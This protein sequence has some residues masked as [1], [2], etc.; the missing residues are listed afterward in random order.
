[1]RPTVGVLLANLGSPAA[2]TTRA[3][4]R[5]LAQ[6]LADRRIVDLPR[7]PWWLLR[8]LIVLPLRS[9]RSAAL[10]RR[11]WT[12]QGSP[13]VATTLRLATAVQAELEERVGG[14]IPVA[15]GMRYGEPSLVAALGRLRDAGAGRIVV[16]PLF[17]QYS[18]ATTASVC[19]ALWSELGQWRRLPDLRVVLDYHAAPRYIAALAA[20]VREHWSAR[21]RDRRLLV[22]FH[23][24]PV[25]YCD[26]G[27]P[28]PAQCTATGRALAEALALGDREWTIAYQSRF[29][30]ERWLEPATDRML[31]AWGSE[32]LETADVVCPGFAADCLETLDEIAVLGGEQF[33][34]AGGGE[35]RYVPALNDRRDHA[36]ALAEIALERMD[37]WLG[38]PTRSSE[39]RG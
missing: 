5:Y 22:S 28:Y 26:A 23:G 19:D 7:L 16:L 21:G 8:T 29:G 9:P 13:L 20:S 27:D 25:R 33:V 14:A 39:A 10:Y 18:S 36:A 3:V 35:L 12:A 24:L 11:I 4:R 6:F 34:A 15:A 17:P 1:M 32:G 37:G 30:R 2:P 31:Q 38:P